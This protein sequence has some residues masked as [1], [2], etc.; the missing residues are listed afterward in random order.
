MQTWGDKQGPN[1]LNDTNNH[2]DADYRNFDAVNDGHIDL[3][4]IKFLS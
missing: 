4:D 2:Y 3:S 1:S